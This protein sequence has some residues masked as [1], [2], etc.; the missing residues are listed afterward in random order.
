[1]LLKDSYTLD[2]FALGSEPGTLQIGVTQDLDSSSLM[3]SSTASRE[4]PIVS[5]DNLFE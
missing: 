3:Y 1:M 5:I 4:V 2:A